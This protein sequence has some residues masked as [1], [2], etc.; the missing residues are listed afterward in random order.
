MPTY[1]ALTLI[2]LYDKYG[3]ILYG[4]AL[5]IAPTDEAATPVLIATFEKAQE[6]N[7]VEN[8]GHCICAT[9]IKL[10]IATA[11]QTING[12]PNGNNP[13]GLQ[14]INPFCA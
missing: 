7:I 4:I 8:H 10:T 14:P 9:L 5:E 6:L 3:A 12:R 13:L 1:S 2:E 11:R